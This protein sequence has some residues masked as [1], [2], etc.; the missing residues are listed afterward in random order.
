MD[1]LRYIRRDKLKLNSKAHTATNEVRNLSKVV[2]VIAL[3]CMT[4][5]I[6]PERSMPETAVQHQSP[7]GLL[8]SGLLCPWHI[9]Y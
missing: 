9:V 6:H 7:K 8:E 1:V 5:T 2:L 4:G 3:S